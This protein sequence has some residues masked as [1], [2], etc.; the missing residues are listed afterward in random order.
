VTKEWKGKK[1]LSPDIPAFATG[2]CR[3][4]IGKQQTQD[5]DRRSRHEDSGKG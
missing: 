5:A 2:K 3:L 4:E 1:F